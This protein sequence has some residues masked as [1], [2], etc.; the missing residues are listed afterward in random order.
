MLSVIRPDLSGGFPQTKGD[1][2]PGNRGEKRGRKVDWGKKGIK[3][4][5]AA[6]DS[7]SYPE[8]Y[9]QNAPVP[10]ERKSISNGEGRDIGTQVCTGETCDGGT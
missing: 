3:E 4:L 9:S 7:L 10:R 2:S 6:P 1:Y 5:A 8:S